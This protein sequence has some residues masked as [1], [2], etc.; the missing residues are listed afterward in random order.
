MQRPY[1][2]VALPAS[3]GFAGQIR[4]RRLGVEV[5][6]IHRLAVSLNAR[7]KTY[8][9]LSQRVHHGKVEMLGL[10]AL[11]AGAQLVKGRG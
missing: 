10:A 5:A 9:P 2:R 7:L 8:D 4:D 3:A 6:I 11:A 1:R